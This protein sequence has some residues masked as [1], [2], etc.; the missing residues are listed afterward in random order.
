M[1]TKMTLE[2]FAKSQGLKV[3]RTKSNTYMS[4]A[5]FIKAERQR[6][7]I[8]DVNS[9]IKTIY[10]TYNSAVSGAGTR[11]NEA[12]SYYADSSDYLQDLK[13][14]AICYCCTIF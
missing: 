11:F 5:D 12:T 6:N 14:K 1:S 3:N 7:R 9:A 2:D 13:K 4:K 10:D 8:N